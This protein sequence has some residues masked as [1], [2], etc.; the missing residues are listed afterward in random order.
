IITAPFNGKTIRPD[1]PVRAITIT[2][3]ALTNLANTAASP[4]TKAPTILTADPTDSGNRTPA[5]LRISKT[6]NSTRVSSMAGRGTPC[7]ADIILSNNGV[8]TISLWNVT[9]DTYNAGILTERKKHIYLII[10]FIEA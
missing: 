7:L 6:N 3:G 9:N 2:I 1:I 10:L 8:G 4:I 5:S